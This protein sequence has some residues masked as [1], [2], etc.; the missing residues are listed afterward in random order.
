[1][2]KVGDRVKIVATMEQL[3]DI[4]IIR[5][6]TGKIGTIEEI[7]LRDAELPFLVEVDDEE[8]WLESGHI[9]KEAKQMKKGD[10]KTGMWVENREG[11]LYLV[12]LGTHEG[13]KIVRNGVEDALS[14]FNNDL[15]A[16]SDKDLDIVRVYQPEITNA[17]SLDGDAKFLWQRPEPKTLTFAEAEKIL[18]DHLGQNV[19]IKAG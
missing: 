19:V 11:N 3:D 7:D 16:M 10:L 18:A 13:D 15:T 12:L 9:E 5:E 2:F 1:M 14:Y 8:W 6:I 4:G 17:L